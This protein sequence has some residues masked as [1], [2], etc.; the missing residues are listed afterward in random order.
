VAPSP[1][2]LADLNRDNKP[3]ILEPAKTPENTNDSIV[4]ALNHTAG[5]FPSCAYP[6]RGAGIGYC[7]P[8]GTVASPVRFTAAANSFGQVRKME[9]WVDG[10]KIGE[11]YHAWGQRAWLDL[12]AGFSAGTHNATIFEADF[13]NRLQKV[14]FPFTVGSSAACTAPASAGVHICQPANNGTSKS[15]VTV[16]A[17]SKI[18]GTLARMEVW[19][20]GVKKFTETTSNS[21]STS[22]PLATGKHRVTVFAVNTAGAKYSATVYVT[23]G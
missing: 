8:A 19:V 18:T 23:V 9:L 22:I 1:P 6:S 14:S 17:A 11:Q 12:S 3:D 21:F 5:S 13:D 7:T 10:K 2:L 16:Q 4:V 20:D 15:P